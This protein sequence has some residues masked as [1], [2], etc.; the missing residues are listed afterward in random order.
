VTSDGRHGSEKFSEVGVE[1]IDRDDLGYTAA[2]KPFPR[3]EIVVRS[4][5]MALGYQVSEVS[6]EVSS[7]LRCSQ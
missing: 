7:I 5:R 2:D 3:G 6:S 1:L 4:Q